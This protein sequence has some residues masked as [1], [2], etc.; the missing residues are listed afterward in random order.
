M[1]LVHLL[2]EFRIG[3]HSG[4]FKGGE[5]GMAIKNQELVEEFRMN[6]RRLEAAGYRTHTA[7]E[8]TLLLKQFM[9]PRE[10]RLV[11]L[12]GKLIAYMIPLQIVNG[13]EELTVTDFALQ[14]PWDDPHLYWLQ[15]PT[16]SKSNR[17][18][19]WFP[20][21]MRL[22]YDEEET[23]NRLID[24]YP[25]QPG[26]VKFGLLLGLG[27]PIPSEFK[28]GDLINGSVAV[29]DQFGT[30][31]GTKIKLWLDRETCLKYRSS[32]T[33]RRTGLFEPLPMPAENAPRA[34]PGLCLM[35]E[36]PVH[37]LGGV[38]EAGTA[39]R[40]RGATE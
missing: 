25:L 39:G 34:A 8:I 26:E 1:Y 13:P 31:H 30:T 6:I 5:R 38:A 16:R 23:L 12:E 40:T 9:G 7:A 28:H 35:Q 18:C 37:G 29:V 15:E 22:H 2:C 19:Y 24:G 21:R 14:M 36:H 10:S 33:Q 32:T 3:E 4:C 17:K 20:G 11:E 27:W